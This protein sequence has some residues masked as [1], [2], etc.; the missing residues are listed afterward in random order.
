MKL[1]VRLPE[2]QDLVEGVQNGGSYEEQPEAR[3]SGEA[4]ETME[5]SEDIQKDVELVGE[6]ETT[7]GLLPDCW[8]CKDEDH[9]ADTE[10]E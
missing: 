1:H 10:E 7:V 9:T 5:Q 3:R 4:L 6:P 2:I 8:M